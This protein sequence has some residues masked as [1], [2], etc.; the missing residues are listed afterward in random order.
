[1]TGGRVRL[2]AI[3]VIAALALAGCGKPH[4][5][6][7]KGGGADKSTLSQ[8]APATPAAPQTP[9]PSAHAL[10]EKLAAP[11]HFDLSGQGFTPWRGPITCAPPI[12]GETFVMRCRAF[13]HDPDRGGQPAIIDIQLFDQDQDFTALDAP[14]KAHIESFHETWTLANTPDITVKSN[15]TGQTRVIP[16]ACHQAIGRR[17]SPAYCTLMQTPRIFITTGVRPDH[18]STHTLNM[19]NTHGPDDASYDAD[20]ASDLAVFVMGQVSAQM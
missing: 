13:L 9:P 3:L 2:A 14:L 8:A 4:P 16:A 6:Q 12:Q 11:V 5:P 19:N 1:M 18:A 15:R 7:V 10:A 17:N 20:H